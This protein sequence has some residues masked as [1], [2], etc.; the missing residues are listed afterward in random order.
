MAAVSARGFRLSLSITIQALD[1]KVPSPS[2]LG[3]HERGHF[4]ENAEPSEPFE[5]YGVG[6]EVEL[7][8][9]TLDGLKVLVERSCSSSSS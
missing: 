2:R 7:S 3:H 9:C 6:K 4:M 5:F 8:L 1:K